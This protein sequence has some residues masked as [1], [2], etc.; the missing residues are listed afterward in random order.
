MAEELQ[1]LLERI[2][3]D[4]IEKADSKAADIIKAAEEKAA[5]IVATAKK[6]AEETLRK[7]EQDGEMF[8]KRGESAIA[9]AAR[10]VILSVDAAVSATL[11]SIVESGVN[12]TFSDTD[13]AALVRDVVLEY[14]KRTSPDNIEVLV[15]EEQQQQLADYFMSKL[16]DQMK[17]GMTIS[18]DHEIISG[19]TVSFK[20]DAV[21]HDFTGEAITNAIT[22]LLRPQLADIVKKATLK[23]QST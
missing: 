21:Y 8:R 10:D 22:T 16:T 19:F 15:S 1:G 13:F 12:K 23:T 4:G 7:A 6:E 11:K 20:D 3:K 17:A 18:G 5:K 14:S 2:Q 9:Q